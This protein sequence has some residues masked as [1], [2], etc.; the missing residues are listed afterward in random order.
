M[1]EVELLPPALLSRDLANSNMKWASASLGWLGSVGVA[2]V[3]PLV[4]KYQTT[5]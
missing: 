4:L 5:K 1:T 3:L 2:L